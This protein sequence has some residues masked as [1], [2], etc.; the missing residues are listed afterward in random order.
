MLYV[1]TKK[2]TAAVRFKATA[3]ALTSAAVAAVVGFAGI[4]PASAFAKGGT[5]PGDTWTVYTSYDATSCPLPDA[6]KADYVNLSSCV[7]AKRT[8]QPRDFYIL[9][10]GYTNLT[11][12]LRDVNAAT[13]VTLPCGNTVNVSKFTENAFAQTSPVP[14]PYRLSVV[15][16][17]IA[18][19]CL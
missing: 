4:L 15:S 3:I 11:P 2:V 1:H 16:N 19:T 18:D 10:D 5:P 14:P 8:G 12:I 9:S 7:L 17:K 6:I 13:T